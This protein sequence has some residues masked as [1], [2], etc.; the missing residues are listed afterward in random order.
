MKTQPKRLA[1]RKE[2]ILAL[3]ASR[4]NQVAGGANPP[5]TNGPG[6]CHFPLTPSH[7]VICGH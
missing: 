4:L 1:L 6:N 2:T 3:E 7:K 5:E